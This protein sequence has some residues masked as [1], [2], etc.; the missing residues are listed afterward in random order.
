MILNLRT[1][2]LTNPKTGNDYICRECKT[3]YRLIHVDY[4]GI[5]EGLNNT[6]MYVG[7]MKCRNSHTKYILLYHRDG[8]WI[9]N[10][11]FKGIKKSD[12]K[13]IGKKYYLRNTVHSV[14]YTFFQINRTLFSKSQERSDT[15]RIIHRYAI[16]E[17]SELVK[18]SKTY[19]DHLNR[20]IIINGK[21]ARKK[22]R[23]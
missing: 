21:S 1:K 4:I 13:L 9:A 22:K 20:P 19:I 14:P 17:P 3:K 5:I 16:E 6:S 18:M 10:R 12:L 2:T 11:Y 23:R 7:T 8:E 15:K